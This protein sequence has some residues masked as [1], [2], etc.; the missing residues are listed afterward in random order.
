MTTHVT[1]AIRQ[2]AGAASLRDGVRD[3]GAR[4]RVYER[5]LLGR[6][7]RKNTRKNCAL[8]SL[9]IRVYR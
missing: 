5:R 8:R 2:V 1:R 6:C 4:R 7:T 9:I 3:S